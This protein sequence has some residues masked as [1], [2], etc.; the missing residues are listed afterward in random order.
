LQAKLVAESATAAAKGGKAAPPPKA[1][2]KKGAAPAAEPETDL[3]E[4]KYIVSC[5]ALVRLPLYDL[6]G[7][8]PA[9]D[10]Y[11]EVSPFSKHDVS[12]VASSDTLAIPKAKLREMEKE[13]AGTEEGKISMR[14][15]VT[16]NPK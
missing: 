15:T 3:G 1:D 9:V 16:T 10:K 4:V 14:V 7:G 11:I 13:R 5:A 2:P 12:V 6:V 8:Q